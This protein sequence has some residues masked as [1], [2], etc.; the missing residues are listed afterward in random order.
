MA[1][2]IL[3]LE[4]RRL[5]ALELTIWE[6]ET[7]GLALRQVCGDSESTRHQS[8]SKETRYQTI[9]NIL[10]ELDHKI[11]FIKRPGE[12]ISGQINFG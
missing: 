5:L 1:K 3:Y 7:L 2:A 9:Q 10:A 11:A 4:V 6:V 12:V 8:I